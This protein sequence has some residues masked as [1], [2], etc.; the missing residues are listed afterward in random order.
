MDSGACDLGAAWNR[1]AYSD[2]KRCEPFH[3]NVSGADGGASHRLVAFYI[4]ALCSTGETGR[5][6]V[7]YINQSAFLKELYENNILLSLGTGFAR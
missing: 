2:I 7:S 6:I 4:V 5:V 1:I 3:G